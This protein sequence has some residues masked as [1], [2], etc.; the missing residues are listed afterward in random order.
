MYD[1][2]KYLSEVRSMLVVVVLVG[3]IWGTMS[4]H[5]LPEPA[6]I[7][8]VPP[9]R[10]DGKEPRGTNNR[11]PDRPEIVTGVLQTPTENE[12][13]AA[14]SGGTLGTDSLL[15]GPISTGGDIAHGK[16]RSA[17]TTHCPIARLLRCDPILNILHAPN[18]ASLY[19]GSELEGEATNG[20]ECKSYAFLTTSGTD[21]VRG[22][23]RLI[24]H[25]MEIYAPGEKDIIFS[26]NYQVISDADA[27]YPF[28]VWKLYP[29][30]H[31]RYDIERIYARSVTRAKTET[32]YESFLGA[33]AERFV[34]PVDPYLPTIDGED[35]MNRGPSPFGARL[36]LKCMPPSVAY[37]WNEGTSPYC[38]FPYA[39]HS[40][41]THRWVRDPWD[42]YTSFLHEGWVEGS[43]V[44]GLEVHGEALHESENL[45]YDG[46]AA[47]EMTAYVKAT[48]D[49]GFT[50]YDW[51]PVH[52]TP[53][54]YSKCPPI[55]YL[56]FDPDNAEVV[57]T[58]H[59]WSERALSK[60]ADQAIGEEGSLSNFFTPLTSWKG[61]LPKFA[62]DIVK[63][64][65]YGQK[66]QLEKG[67]EPYETIGPRVISSD[68]SVEE[69]HFV[70]NE[71]LKVARSVEVR[72]QLRKMVL[73]TETTDVL[74][75]NRLKSGPR[76]G[77]NNRCTESSPD[78]V[79]YAIDKLG[80]GEMAGAMNIHNDVPSNT[81]TTYSVECVYDLEVLYNK[82][83][84]HDALHWDKTTTEKLAEDVLQPLVMKYLGGSNDAIYVTTGHGLWDKRETVTKTG[85]LI[86]RK[87][88]TVQTCHAHPNET[89]ACTMKSNKDYYTEARCDYEYTFLRSH[90]PK[91]FI[92]TGYQTGMCITS[93]KVSREI[94]F[95]HAP[96]L[97]R[98]LYSPMW[99]SNDD[100]FE[101]LKVF[102]DDDVVF[103][104]QLKS[105]EYIGIPL[106]VD[107]PEEEHTCFGAPDSA[108]L[109]YVRNDTL[110]HEVLSSTKGIDITYGK[111][112]LFCPH[113]HSL[114]YSHS[115]SFYVASSEHRHGV[116]PHWKLTLIEHDTSITEEHLAHPILG[117]ITSEQHGFKV[118]RVAVPVAQLDV[119]PDHM[120]FVGAYDAPQHNCKYAYHNGH[121]TI[122]P[123]FFYLS[124]VIKDVRFLRKVACRE[125]NTNETCLLSL[126]EDE[127]PSI[128][129]FIN[130]V[131]TLV[132]CNSSNTTHG[133]WHT[134]Y[135]TLRVAG[136]DLAIHYETL[137]EAVAKIHPTHTSTIPIPHCTTSTRECGFYIPT[138]PHTN[139]FL[140]FYSP[141]SPRRR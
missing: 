114:R 98:I 133:A 90:P 122:H 41:E 58:M 89:Q 86:E 121:S 93:G 108:L 45:F 69:K 31:T 99:N 126:A 48:G 16:V 53:P 49:S 79:H 42:I 34:E 101:W 141:G 84:I 87:I 107:E 106:S 18:Y 57:R 103:L 20:E 40:R 112:A 130:K 10:E 36:V 32:G 113:P 6:S 125:E 83:K 23:E 19:Q 47:E 76:N 66:W 63:N 88:T 95:C 7:C 68:I 132:L 73:T 81:H 110:F 62:S 50:T 67:V 65:V 3:L 109:R 102:K 91:P 26:C 78:M 72:G 52:T 51:S 140:V 134:F 94:D 2:G 135:D 4:Q 105:S 14:S 70:D 97:E 77:Q 82:T 80:Y 116:N 139:Q 8:D 71:K 74:E 120:R 118:P 30:D 22:R 129:S 56:F 9:V 124:P 17:L 61:T 104:N 92:D 55:E 115:Q 33:P 15:A 131:P 138:I 43:G 37:R 137:L 39:Q 54:I 44:N 117:P 11:S 5:I 25:S 29:F 28:K 127:F 46:I 60:G 64:N 1:G 13:N 59:G 119:V 136:G 38:S 35:V 21:A 96:T 24:F 27:F 123:Q 85:G 111:N 75:F 128:Q 12:I 100:E